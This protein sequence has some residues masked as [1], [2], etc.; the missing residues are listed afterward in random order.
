VTVLID[1]T[2]QAPFAPLG[3]FPHKWGKKS[4]CH[5]LK[6]IPPPL[7]REVSAKLTEGVLLVILGAFQ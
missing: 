1:I 7:A 2:P 5:I 3:H 6:P 4:P